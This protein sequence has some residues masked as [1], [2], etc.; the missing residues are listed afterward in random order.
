MTGLL[1]TTVLLHALASIPDPHPVDAANAA[2]ASGDWADAVTRYGTL[3]D[4]NP[5][6][7]GY[8]VRLGLAQMRIDR[9]DLALQSFAIARKLG[10]Y[11][12]STDLNSARC[13]A[14]AGHFDRAVH[15][16]DRLAASGYDD[17][18]RLESDTAFAALRTDPRVQL[19]SGTLHLSHLNQ[20]AGWRADLAYLDRV[21]RKRH[22]NLFHT[23]SEAQWTAKVAA[24]HEAI[25][26]L[27]DADISA[28]LT[29]LVASIGD[30]HTNLLPPF[31]GPRA[32]G[33]LPLKPYLFA[34]GAYVR[35]AQPDQAALVGARLLTIDQQPLEVVLDTLYQR[36]NADNAM[37]HRWLSEVGL[38]I[39]N[40]THDGDGQQVY[41]TTWTLQT[42]DGE[43]RQVA[44]NAAPISENI[45]S[46]GDPQ[47]WVDAGANPP[48]LYRSRLE[49]NYWFETLDNEP[50]VYLQFNQ[51]RKDPDRP[52]A[53]FFD[54]AL[55]A[56]GS[57]ALVIDLRHN[58]GGN[59]TLNRHLMHPL[60][61]HPVAQ[62]RGRLF[63]I[64]GRR[65]FS[66]A[67]NLANDLDRETEAIFVGEPTGS[68]PNFYGENHP[69]RLPYSGLQGSVSTRYWQGGASSADNRIWI[70]PDLAAPLSFA[71]YQA[72]RD[73]ALNAIRDYLGRHR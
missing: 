72:G 37:T 71:D 9:C 59:N 20:V 25:P 42:R 70:A 68:K 40:P 51:V 57:G 45:M 48:P 62:N 4:G 7:A 22:A 13:E 66:A 19:L 58:N 36:I 33:V 29:I 61:G 14:L 55:E 6:H 73:P 8:H 31:S 43:T 21:M 17:W 65:T 46:R 11:R 16:L 41:A 64:I 47:G 54:Q 35:A 63:V 12:F 52:M 39:V 5:W 2:W 15:W 32:V 27:S 60:V 28:R 24:L 44:L 10:G 38:R 69:Y 18:A 1:L 49:E 23:L 3:V 67:Q 34:D 26:G 50:M 30:G 53:E 56:A